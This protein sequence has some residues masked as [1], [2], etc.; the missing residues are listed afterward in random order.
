[1]L[2]ANLQ[3]A[4]DVVLGFRAQALLPIRQKTGDR[5]SCRLSW[6]IGEHNID[7]IAQLQIVH[8]LIPFDND[9][10]VLLWLCCSLPQGWKHSTEKYYCGNC[11]T[12]DHVLRAT[13]IPVAAPVGATWDDLDNELVE[14]FRE[15]TRASNWMT[16]EL[17]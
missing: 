11:W 8:F 10:S 12:R 6:C 1:M 2:G 9:N 15:T 3:P 17:A 4:E 7:L 16:M 5:C 14:M 13:I